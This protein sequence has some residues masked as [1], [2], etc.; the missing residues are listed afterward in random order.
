MQTRSLWQGLWC[1]LFVP[2]APSPIGAPG[3]LKFQ[4]PQSFR[5][6]CSMAPHVSAPARSPHN[7]L[8]PML[9]FCGS[10]PR[11]HGTHHPEAWHWTFSCISAPPFLSGQHHAIPGTG[12]T[13][14]S[15][16]GTLRLRD[17]GKERV[18]RD[19]SLQ[20]GD[21]EVSVQKARRDGNRAAIHDAQGACALGV[22]TYTGFG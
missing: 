9:E 8:P 7:T 4:S 11:L 20:K 12:L 18:D 16:C 22:I 15:G 1:F 13:P 2:L 14:C 5:W 6:P 21:R 17:K 10:F 3:R 19:S